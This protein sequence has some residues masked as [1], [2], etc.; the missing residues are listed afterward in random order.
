ME[1][2]MSSM[3]ESAPRAATRRAAAREA[4]VASAADDGPSTRMGASMRNRVGGA[5]AMAAIRR[6]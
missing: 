1:L 6:G 2:T 4:E 5:S 3:A